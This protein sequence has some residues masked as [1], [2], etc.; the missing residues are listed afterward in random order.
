MCLSNTGPI[1]PGRPKPSFRSY[2]PVPLRRREDVAKLLVSLADLLPPGTFRKKRDEFVEIARMH[3][4]ARQLEAARPGKP[5]VRA[6]LCSIRHEAQ[7][8][9]DTL[10]AISNEAIEKVQH[11][12]WPLVPVIATFLTTESHAA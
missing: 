7:A 1:K 4:A 6:T 11:R 5:T 3:I 8:T 12:Y 10:S 2:K 9:A